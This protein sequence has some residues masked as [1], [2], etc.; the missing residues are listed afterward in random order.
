MTYEEFRA[1]AEKSAD[2]LKGASGA[3]QKLIKSISKSLQAGD[4]KTLR[5]DSAALVQ[6]AQ[7][8][9]DAAGANTT[10]AESFDSAGYFASGAFAEKL[11]EECAAQ[12]VDV[13]GNFPEYEMFPYKVRIDAE[14]QDIY[15]NKK[16]VQTMDASRFVET[17]KAGQEKLRKA[18][19]NA[20]AFANDLEFAYNNIQN[21]AKAKGK[22]ASEHVNLLTV[23]KY[24]APMSRFRKDYDINAF[25]YDIAK[26]YS[27]LDEVNAGRATRIELGPGR[28]S[29]KA[30]RII[31]SYGKEHI[32]ANIAFKA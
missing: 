30:I 2:S 31:D 16:K 7:T 25:S 22:K 32:F 9:A 11:V 17:V 6:A 27:A 20:A 8:L 14:N 10:V 19:F 23:Y 3:C 12:G 4:V 5:K 29:D 28:V 1:E 26:L 21:E 24:L 13:I 18:G 15:L